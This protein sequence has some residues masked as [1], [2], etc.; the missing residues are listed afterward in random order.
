MSETI[1]PHIVVVDD[2]P[3]IRDLLQEYLA[4]NE[5]RVSVTSTGKQMSANQSSGVD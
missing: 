2:D 1:Q 3:Q 4:H 5:L